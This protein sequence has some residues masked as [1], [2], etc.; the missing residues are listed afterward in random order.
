MSRVTLLTLTRLLTALTPDPVLLTISVARYAALVA[1]AF[2]AGTI[3]AVVGGGGLI[4]LPALLLL[5]PTQPTV[6]LLGT[7]KVASVFGTGSAAVIYN[8]RVA[9]VRREAAMMAALAALGSLAGAGLATLVSSAALRPIVLIALLA[10]L[11]YVWRNPLLGVE[12]R[13]LRSPAMRRAVIAA[14]G[15]AIG[16]YDGFIGPGTGSFLV[17]LLVG[18]IGM[19]FLR[20]SAMAKVVNF[21]TN[22]AAIAVFA[23]QRHVL[24][25]VGLAMG[26]GNAVGAQ[27]G[28]RLAIGRG[29][30]WVRKAFLVVVSALMV[31]L[32]YDILR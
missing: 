5:L 17:F 1:S 29:T 13:D 30:V 21:A 31:R 10:V 19:D 3:D 7:N 6:M 18:V 23:S 14:G 15:V 9:V 27:L 11:V 2:S 25:S 12:H 24:W 8:R 4:Q 20:A 28:A 32:A 26:A 22:A 16:M